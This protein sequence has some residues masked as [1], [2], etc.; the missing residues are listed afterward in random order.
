[1]HFVIDV[2]GGNASTCAPYEVTITAEDASNNTLTDYTGTIGINTSTSNGDWSI[3]SAN[4]SL[5]PGGSDGGSA[6]YTFAANSSDNG[7]I[8]LDLSNQHAE[9]LTITVTDS[10]N[11]VSSTSAN[12]SFSE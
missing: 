1:D 7:V 4:G 6:N 11:G 8:T 3:N 9:T 12:V 5:S 2:G 10:D